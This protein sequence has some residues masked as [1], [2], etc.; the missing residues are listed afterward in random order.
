MSKDRN[1][2]PWLSTFA[3][4]NS[5]GV[6]VLALFGYLY[7]R[8]N[9]GP[10]RGAKSLHKATIE[11]P[12]CGQLN[13]QK[14]QLPKDWESF[15]PPSVGKSYVDTS[16]G[17]PVERLTD[18]SREEMLPDGT[19]PSLNHYYSTFSPMNETDSMVMIGSDDGEW[20]IKDLGGATIVGGHEMPQMNS[21]H[22]VWDALSGDSFY[23]T[24][25]SALFRGIVQDHRVKA[26]AIH[27]FKEYSGI[28]SPDAADLSQDGEHIALVG[29]NPDKSMDLF[30]WSLKTQTKTSIY[31]TTCKVQQWDVTQSPQ[32]GCV[33]KLQLTP[34]DLLSIQFSEDGEEKEQGLRLWKDDKLT[35]LQDGTNHYDTGY[36]LQGNPIFIE[37]GRN[38]TLPG[39]KNPCPSG[40]GLDVRQL[41]D[42]SSS[43][44]L[45]DRQ[46]SWHVSYRGDSEQPW[47]VLSFFDDRTNGPEL[48]NNNPGFQTPSSSNWHLY[49]DEILLTSID[50]RN[51][52]RLA[53]AR[54]RSAENYWAT[55]RA[56]I[57]RDGKYVVF[58]SNMA[59]ANG[60]PT[61]MHDPHD[62]TDVYLIKVR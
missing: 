14:V 3:F 46:P 23:Y 32:P 26:A 16:F 19:H 62:C 1:G 42:L 8:G 24:R 41:D 22:P 29:Q 52:Y 4:L 25:G 9:P 48:F 31:R 51:Q 36:D 15:T 54:S 55:P 11:G 21:G 44:C 33:H 20:R 30:V 37:M 5:C 58:D 40:W 27:V 35:R 59:Y 56:T 13:N 7:A 57:S 47:A 50:G 49:E 34:N 12:L 10:P 45:L 43:T 18:S 61:K 53:Q 6:I 2:N 60:C 28:V 38:S 39:D 17:C